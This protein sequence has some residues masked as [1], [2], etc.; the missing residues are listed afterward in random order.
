MTTEHEIIDFIEGKSVIN[1]T[2]LDNAD[3]EVLESDVINPS[4]K[5]TK[6]DADLINV[7]YFSGK[8]GDFTR[9]VGNS[10]LVAKAI[11]RPSNN[12]GSIEDFNVDT[13][14]ASMIR[15]RGTEITQIERRGK[16]TK[17]KAF[18]SRHFLSRVLMWWAYTL[19]IRYSWKV[20]KAKDN[21][22]RTVVW[23]DTDNTNSNA[24][25]LWR[26][27]IGFDHKIVG[28]TVLIDGQRR[29]EEY[30]VPLERHN[31]VDCLTGDDVIL[32]I[33]DLIFLIR[34]KTPDDMKD[35]LDRGQL[36]PQFYELLRTTASKEKVT[37][38]ELFQRYKERLYYDEQI[39]EATWSYPKLDVGYLLKVIEELQSGYYLTDLLT[40][41]VHHPYKFP[42]KCTD[43][44]ADRPRTDEEHLEAKDDYYLPQ[45][46]EEW[47]EL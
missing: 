33:R 11:R 22:G 27:T 37:Y 3:T 21:E 10:H 17:G 25:E 36:S 46:T 39:G 28:K 9:V 32:M 13:Y 6:S 44:T 40:P 19:R 15:C 26:H 24:I 29:V 16:T 4:K 34:N 5:S 12:F 43:M 31:Q 41:L 30:A 8:R 35:A 20:V 7:L 2:L 45:Y 42:L 38:T 18:I 1:D 47:R 23:V 14:P